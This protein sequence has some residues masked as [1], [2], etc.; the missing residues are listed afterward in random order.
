TYDVSDSIPI[1]RSLTLADI[2]NGYEKT[3][4]ALLLA[5]KNIDIA[6]LVL[7]ERRSDRFPTVSLSGN[8]NFSRTDNKATVNPFSPLFSRNHGFNYGINAS[9]PI[10]KIYN[11]RRHIQ[12]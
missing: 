3:S 1:N 10:F 7:R 11:V 4:P 5:Q 9:I 8:Y 6:N 2:Q 12:Q